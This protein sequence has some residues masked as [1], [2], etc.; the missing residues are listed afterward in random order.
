[1]QPTSRLTPPSAAR[2]ALSVLLMAATPAALSA[3]QQDG[4]EAPPK[5]QQ[6]EPDAEQREK[7]AELIINERVMVIG[8]ADRAREIPG[9]A[10]FLTLDDL[11]QQRQAFGDVHRMLRQLP[12][13]N[14]QEEEGFGLRPNIGLRGSGSERSA[15]IT[16]M[17][18]GVLIA[19]APYAA[20]AAYYFPSAGRMEAIEVRKGSSQVK[21]GPRT[22][23]GAIN[24]VSTSIPRQF[25]ARARVAAG[26]YGTARALLNAGGSGERYGWL[27]E[28]YQIRTGGFKQLDGGG[29]TGYDL[30]DYLGKLRINSAPGARVYQDLEVKLGLTRQTS[31]ETYLGLTDE[32]FHA[33]PLRRY[34]GSQQDV[35]RSDHEQ[36]QVRHFAALGAGID[37]TTVAY[38]NNFARNWYKLQSVN[39]V[40]LSALF[41]DPVE[42]A[43]E[44]AIARGADSV[45]DALQVRANNRDYYGQGVQSVIG[46]RPAVGAVINQ[47]EIGIRYHEDQEDRFQHQDGYRMV[48]GT[49]VLTSAG[50]PGSQSNRVSDAR[51]WAVFVQDRIN[52]GRWAIIPGVRFESIDLVRTD[53]SGDDPLRSAP[54]RV[55]TNQVDVAVPGVGVSY[56][57]SV[58]LQ[59]YGGV[60][61]GFAP[62][63]PGTTEF[64]DAE[65][66]INYELGARYDRGS[67]ALDITGFFNDYSNLL[68]ADT[69]ASGGSGT[70]DLFNGGAVNVGGLEASARFAWTPTAGWNLPLRTAYTYTH[71][72]FQDEFISDYE[73]WGKVEAGDR[74]PYLPEHQLS[75][76]IGVERRR[77]H[78]DIEATFNGAMRTSASQGPIDPLR[79]IEGFL[80][81]DLS[82]DFAV[83][84]AV[85]VFAAIENLTDNLYVVARRPAG[86]R[87]GL[88]RTAL[89]GARLDF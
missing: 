74:L 62:P 48:N 34:A 47:L 87:P 53:Y 45:D 10:Y 52:W 8:G 50:A 23:G 76:A 73:P 61:Q 51:A 39:G 46:W 7:N 32:D 11:E 2:I 54:T 67:L 15:K 26:A 30:H 24:L 86:A 70:G 89:V 40:G 49:M 29:D 83:S 65:Q 84:D 38:R 13:I 88:P 16:L 55:R 56:D 71:A 85:V 14:I 64:T 19:P 57:A 33:D 17:E 37:V 81:W 68:G 22:N 28:T 4:A 77:W 42:F 43:D 18:D 59:I 82:G 63:G 35:F 20:P 69:L 25:D 80:V 79:D 41:D 6:S 31:H 3:Q 9:S 5:A 60:H 44:L 78:V 72:T 58:G 66:S 27:L 12:G 36:Y 21:Y 1:M 75:G